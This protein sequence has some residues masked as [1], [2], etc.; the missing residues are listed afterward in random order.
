MIASLVHIA[1]VIFYF[2]F[3]SGDEQSWATNSTERQVIT[4]ETDE[5]IYGA[6]ESSDE[7]QHKKS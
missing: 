3:S 7:K 4:E 2:V 1:T 6:T 5:A